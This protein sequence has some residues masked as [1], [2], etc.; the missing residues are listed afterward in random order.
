MESNIYAYAIKLNQFC[1]VADRPWFSAS[2]NYE[3]ISLKSEQFNPLSLNRKSNILCLMPWHL[4]LRKLSQFCRVVLVFAI[5][6]NNTA[7]FRFM[8][9]AYLSPHLWWKILIYIPNIPYIYRI[10]ICSI[11]S[12][13]NIIFCRQN[14]FAIHLLSLCISLF[15]LAVQTLSRSFGFS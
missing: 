8:R 11:I 2:Q 4:D 5:A 14:R 1:G 6:H 10:T 7:A 15:Q 12:E 13:S 3:A 9:C